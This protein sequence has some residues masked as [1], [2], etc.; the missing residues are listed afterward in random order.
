MSKQLAAH[1]GGGGLVRAQTTAR[2]T[3]F[4]WQPCPGRQPPAGSE[5]PRERIATV[6]LMPFHLLRGGHPSDHSQT[7]GPAPTCSPRWAQ[8]GKGWCRDT[9]HAAPGLQEAPP[10]LAHHLRALHACRWPVPRTLPRLEPKVRSGEAERKQMVPRA[11]EAQVALPHP[12]LLAQYLGSCRGA[13]R[14]AGGRRL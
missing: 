6:G 10:V 3:P 7:E 12:L 2:Q 14:L 11:G 8:V 1:F 5:I 13:F 4:P 9:A